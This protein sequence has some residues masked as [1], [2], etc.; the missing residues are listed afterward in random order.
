MWAMCHANTATKP[1]ASS[2]RGQ[3]LFS[4][5]SKRKQ[6][7]SL[8]YKFSTHFQGISVFGSVFISLIKICC[9][10]CFVFRVS[11]VKATKVDT[12]TFQRWLQSRV[13]AGIKS[14]LAPETQISLP[15]D[16]P[17]TIQPTHMLKDNCLLQ[18]EES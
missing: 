7:H 11:V 18:K 2:E 1:P 13:F 3:S 5:A 17:Q 6:R 14:G 4:S 15:F 10:A 16:S 12:V 9:T 8:E